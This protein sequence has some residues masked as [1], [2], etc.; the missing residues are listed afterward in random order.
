MDALQAA[1]SIAGRQYGVLSL[2]QV[3]RCGLAQ[4]ELR[5]LL[6]RGVGKRVHQGVYRDLGYA[7]PTPRGRLLCAAMAA[8]VAL[9]PASFVSAETAARLWGVQGLP[10]WDG[11]VHLTIPAVGTQSRTAGVTL[12]TWATDAAEV[13]TR[14]GLRLTNPERTLRDVL[15][16]VDRATAVCVLDSALNLGR[17]TA[18]RLAGLAAANTGRP[19][20][21]RSL[22]WW[23]LADGRAQSPL[24]TRVRLICTDAGEPPDDLQHRFYGGHGRLIGVGDLWWED[25]RL[26]VETDG[27]GPHELPEAL[28]HDRRRQN[29]LELDYPGIRIIRFTWADLRFPTYIADSVRKADRS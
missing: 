13:T 6:V 25:R 21:T 22:P 28:L 1:R 18:G 26:L 20:G 24:E 29:A 2:A 16:H 12:H 17:V 5:S 4:R 3:R 8:Q 10:L 11:S 7:T 15:L 23:T 9:G 27:R 19:G 14:G